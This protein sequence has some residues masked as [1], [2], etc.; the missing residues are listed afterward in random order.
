MEKILLSN[1][2][3]SVPQQQGKGKKIAIVNGTPLIILP[4]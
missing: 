3:E 4:S 1:F 2:F